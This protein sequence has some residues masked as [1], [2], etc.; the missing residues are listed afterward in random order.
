MLEGPLGGATLYLNPTDAQ[1]ESPEYA[2]V[3]GDREFSSSLPAMKSL[4]PRVNQIFIDF[5]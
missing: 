3:I 2:T 5:D 1:E 4:N